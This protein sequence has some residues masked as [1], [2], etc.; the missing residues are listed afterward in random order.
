MDIVIIGG[1]IA[2]ANAARE[3][4]DRGHDGTIVVLAAEH[5]LPYE[6]PPLSKGILL[7]DATPESAHV[8]EQHWY[9]EH[10]VDLRTGTEVTAIDLDRRQVHAGGQSTPYDRLLIATGATP[11]HLDDLDSAEVPVTYLRTLDDSVAL[12]RV[13]TGTIL[14]V[15]AGW[16]GL[17][18]AAAAR[19]AGADVTVVDPADQPLAAVLG[20]ELG[21]RFADLHRRHGVDLRMGVTVESATGGSVRLTDGHELS[22][23]LVVVGIG[24]VPDDR[25]AR[26]AGLAVDNGILVDSTLRTSD[27]YVFAVGDVANHQH[28]VLG[29]RI[30]VE[31]WDTA[32]HQGRAAARAM[33]G[34]DEPYTRMPYFFTDQYD[35]GMEYVGSVG[36]DGHDDMVVRGDDLVAGLTV[37]WAR[38]GTVVAGMQSNDW[39]ATDTIRALV[40]AP[41]PEGFGD[42]EV[43]LEKLR[44]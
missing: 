14:V 44:P 37:L 28:P 31:H 43:P 34:E 18:V 1:G 24:A 21:A 19:Q 9:D 4:R 39:D 6:R 2:A 33:L 13:L 5:H 3:L 8:L 27:P 20:P 36:P 38:D 26:E 10:D 15:G 41:V 12:A 17:E 11:R 42:T 32:Q 30:R 22:P 16:I 40:G 29:R 23:D 35:M 7:G 25:L